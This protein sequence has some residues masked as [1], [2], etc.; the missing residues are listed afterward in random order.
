[1]SECGDQSEEFSMGEGTEEGRRDDGCSELGGGRSLGKEM[2][3]EGLMGRK[4]KRGR[5][6]VK[7]SKEYGVLPRWDD[8]HGLAV[9]SARLLDHPSVARVVPGG[10]VTDLQTPAAGPELTT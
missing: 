4:W 9:P 2:G 5:W 3:D 10:S 8:C 7:V 1:M 6:L